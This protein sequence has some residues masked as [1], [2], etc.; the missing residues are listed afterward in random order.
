MARARAA[1]LLVLA[2]LIMVASGCGGE[3][4]DTGEPVPPS[5]EVVTETMAADATTGEETSTLEADA[6]GDPEAGREV[7]SSAGCTS[8]HTLA[9]AGSSGTVGPNLDEAKPSFE[10]AVEVVTNG[11]GAMPAFGDQLS[12]EQIRDVAAFVSESAGGER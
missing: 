2:A 10:T 12:E 11:R 1:C 5:T 3:D 7:F 9:A 6:E 8:C 4:L